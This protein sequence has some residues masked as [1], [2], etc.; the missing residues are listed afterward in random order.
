MPII[1]KH[2]GSM[3]V[4]PIL[5]AQTIP[6]IKLQFPSLPSSTVPSKAG[7][8]QEGGQKCQWAGFLFKKPISACATAYPL[9]TSLCR[10]ISGAALVPG[11]P[12]CCL[13]DRGDPVHPAGEHRV[14]VEHL[15]LHPLHDVL[16]LVIEWDLCGHESIRGGE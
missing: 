1:W 9:E 10:H 13:D 2:Y 6:A 7:Q 8:S 16:P 3:G 4:R 14:T 11:T 5:Y 15:H 12:T